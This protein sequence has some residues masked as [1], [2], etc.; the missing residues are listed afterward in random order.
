MQLSFKTY[1]RQPFNAKSFLRKLVSASVLGQAL[2]NSSG[3][4]SA[5]VSAGLRLEKRYWALSQ[6]AENTQ[7]NRWRAF[8]TAALLVAFPVFIQA[9]LV[10]IAPALSFALTALWLWLGYRW[11]KDPALTLWGDLIVGFSWTWL[12]GSVY[13]GW[14]RT[15]PYIHLP[16][17]A[18]GLPIVL[19][20]MFYGKAKIG[21]YFYLGSL[22]GTAITDL[23]FY[24]V[25]LIPYWRSLMMSPPADAGS[26]LHGAL[27]R[28][29][30]YEGVGYAIVLLTLLVML[31][32]IPM[33]SRS[34]KWWAF[35]GAILSTILVDS[36]FFV[37]AILS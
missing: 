37:A 3:E 21:N 7:Q 32:T 34:T 8:I 2:S 28:M 6:V 25:G 35:S 16:L 24:C 23:Y 33:R 5:I 10:R 26:I 31:G 29:E 20:L 27:L 1:A 22:L 18:L 36:L 4:P 13:W 19:V 15:N 30:T 14:F 17:E 11:M 12:A 9:P